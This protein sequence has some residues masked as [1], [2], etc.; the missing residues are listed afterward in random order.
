LQPALDTLRFPVAEMP[1]LRYMHQTNNPLIIVDVEHAEEDLALKDSPALFWRS[2]V[3]VP[4]CTPDAII[5][6]IN[7]GSQTPN[8]FTPIHADR[9]QAFA[10]QAAIAIH[11][12]RLH[13]ETR[14]LAAYHERQR[15]ARD[16]HDAVSQT[17]FA[18]TISTEALLRQWRRDPTSIGQRL[19]DLY[20]LTRGALAETRAVLLELRPEALLEISFETLLEQLVEAI[21]SRKKLHFVLELEYQG[22]LLPESKLVLYR[23]TQEALN[24]VVKHAQASQVM[25]R[26]FERET[27]LV[28]EISDNGKGFDLANVQSTSMGLDIMRERAQSAGA[29]FAI[30]STVGQGTRV[31][32]SWELA[33]GKGSETV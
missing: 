25:I 24:N 26:L 11:N 33:A 16:L 7:L 10:E 12:A 20:T 2:Y 4:I 19:S 31:E 29:T 32:V 14:E 22:G 23:I 18:A 8:F 15:L 5:G 3:G 28:L 21:Q 27:D 6:F 1:N 9:L 17:L 30:H 13:E